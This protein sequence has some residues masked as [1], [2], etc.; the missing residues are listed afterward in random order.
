MMPKILFLVPKDSMD[1][2]QLKY[3]HTVYP[4]VSFVFSDPYDPISLV[5]KNLDEGPMIVA[6]RGNSATVIREHFPNIHVVQ[7][8]ITGYD[9]IRSLD[10]YNIA[11]ATIAVIT[12]N[13]EISG[14]SIF[15]KLYSIRI[16]SYLMVPYGNLENVIRDAVIQGAN[17]I[18][19][20]A[21][22]CKIA[23]E[24]KTSLKAIPL[25]LGP[26]TMSSTLREIKQVQEAIKVENSR[27]NFISQLFDSIANGIISVDVNGKIMLVNSNASR[28][29]QI[30]SHHLIGKDIEEIL[31][32]NTSEESETIIDI[33]ENKILVTHNPLQ[34]ENQESVI[35]YTLREL[36]LIESLKTQIRRVEYNHNKHLARFSFKNIIGKSNSIRNAV[37]IGKNYGNTDS[38]VLISGETGTGKEMFAQ[39][40]HN[41]GNRCNN[42]F[43][44]VNCAALPETLLESELF[45]YVEGAFTGAIRKG[46]PGLFETAHGGTIFLDEISEISY[47]SQGKLLRVL[48]EKY[49]VRL[50]SQKIIPIN[51]R[52]IAATNQD[53][54]ELVEKKKFREDL[55][56]RLNVLNI[57]IP[58]VR[59]REGDAEILL[60]YFL[61]KFGSNIS[62][63][64]SA[65]DFINQY[66]WYGNV[67]EISN[68]AERIVAT[69]TDIII[70]RKQIEN[71]LDLQPSLEQSSN[72]SLTPLQLREKTQEEEIKNAMR[73]ANGN[74]GKAAD[75]LKINRSTLWRRMKKLNM[76]SP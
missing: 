24:M 73:Q 18:L 16:I 62:L 28:M 8:N 65:T 60:N 66:T 36:S 34:N 71:L 50:G 58:P 69:T 39:S 47:T 23:D 32:V 59:E 37:R 63:S 46:K 38:N 6:G 72:Q 35:I 43:V 2:K 13:L 51:V 4:N 49:I 9:I 55:Y 57:I 42:A 41:S 10:K 20:G 61:K 54:R 30:Q 29:L 7:I 31:G 21:L 67:R 27:Q 22:T 11:G 3:Y 40:I 33:N 44:A 70:T 53:L 64:N 74:M 12:N 25:V 68:L 76:T 48:Q 14:L 5:Q 15:E 45:G 56:Y 52:V 75:I 17:F 19:G 26:E 1:D